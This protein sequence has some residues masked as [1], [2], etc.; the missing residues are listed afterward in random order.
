MEQLKESSVCFD[1]SQIFMKELNKTERSRI[2]DLAVRRLLSWDS[3]TK[4]PWDQAALGISSIGPGSTWL[5][6]V[7][8][9]VEYRKRSTLLKP[10]NFA[11]PMSTFKMLELAERRVIKI[12][13]NLDRKGVIAG[14]IRSAIAHDVLMDQVGAEL[15]EIYEEG[16]VVEK[17]A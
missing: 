15:E 6:V 8:M 13:P 2:L 7:E 14:I 16:A 11:I 17:S 5:D 3:Y 10:V 4:A 1:E 9:G 12:R